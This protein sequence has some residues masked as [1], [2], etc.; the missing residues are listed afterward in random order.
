[1]YDDGLVRIATELYS[2]EADSILDP[3]IHVTNYDINRTNKK[4]IYNY[5]PGSC[6]GHKWRLKVLWKYFHEIGLQVKKVLEPSM[7]CFSL[8]ISAVFYS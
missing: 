5:E 4:F 2:E 3:C 1:M 6:N 7:F 8:G